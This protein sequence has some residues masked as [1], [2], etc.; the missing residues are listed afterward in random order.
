[1]NRDQPNI[2]RSLLDRLI[3]AEPAV[4]RDPAR[5]RQAS[6]QEVK[7]TVIRDLEKLL[8][9]KAIVVAPPPSY[10]ELH[11][12]LYTY[13]LADFTALNP[14]STSV[15]QKLRQEIE[16]AIQRFEPR[17]K[18]VTVR[19]E[20]AS[21]GE[22][23]SMTRAGRSGESD[24]ALRFKITGLLVIDPL[25]EPVAFDTYFDVSRNE[26]VIQK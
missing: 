10:R 14:R 19:I 13:G 2:Q 4:S 21:Q 1:M 7:A 23:N 25:T 8:N 15:R 18:N 6:M 26:Y 12:S 24:R 17:L 20:M 16:A 9:T 5:Y 3:D 11:K 22:R